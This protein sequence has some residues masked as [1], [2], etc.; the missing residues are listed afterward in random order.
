MTN[1]SP[2]RTA[3]PLGSVITEHPVAGAQQIIRIVL[4][5]FCLLVAIDCIYLG[6]WPRFGEF[7]A[8]TFILTGMIAAF[9]FWL[10]WDAFSHY[11]NARRQRIVQH[12]Y[13][14]RVHDAKLHQD[15]RFEDIASVGGVLWQTVNGQRPAGGVI[16]IDE[17]QGRR[18]ELPSP[19][20]KTHELGEIIRN[21]TFDQRLEAA[22]NSL[23]KGENV[24]FGRVT[25]SSLLMTVQGDVVPRGAIE[26][27]RVSNRWLAIKARGQSERLVPTEEIPNLD[28]LLALL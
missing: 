16:W 18:V 21:R 17:V 14:F 22:Q 12:E 7:H 19:H 15:V 3:D 24:P 27:A 23:A 28:V 8:S 9:F 11:A 2:Y 26:Y 1:P 13:G 25:L 20:A 6:M 4:G 10:S 5:C